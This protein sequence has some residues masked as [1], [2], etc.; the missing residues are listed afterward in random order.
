M[1]HIHH[2]RV[3]LTTADIAK[4]YRW[5]ALQGKR[6][7]WLQCY[8]GLDGGELRTTEQLTHHIRA[9]T[10]LFRFPVSEHFPQIVFTLRHE[11]SVVLASLG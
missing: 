8:R 1:H 10:G 9:P 5:C 11:A 6:P 2:L 3:L 4:G 7:S